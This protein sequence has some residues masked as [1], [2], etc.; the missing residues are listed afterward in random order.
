[1][2]LQT[3]SRKQAKIKMALQGP[4]GS[5]KTKSALLIAYGLCSCWEQIAVIDTEN[6]SADL[7]ADLGGYKVLPLQAPFTP[8]RYIEAIGVCI[9]AGMQ[10][11]I[12]DSLSHE[13]E[14]IGGVLD[15]HSHMIGNSFTNWSKLTPRHNAFVQTML[16]ANVHVIGTI[17][18]KQEY[19]LS[20]KN[21]KQVPEKVGLKGIQR[22][23]LDYEFTIAFDL[24][25]SLHAKASK[26][27]T[28]LFFNQPEFILS[29]DTGRRIL[30]WCGR[31]AGK[32]E[33]TSK[34]D[35]QRSI[36]DSNSIDQLLTLHQA[37]PLYQEELLPEFTKRRQDIMNTNNIANQ[38]HLQNGIRSNTK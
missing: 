27:R 35:M 4:S 1:M 12:I 18:S 29:A 26:D 3:A 20:D 25:I 5:G 36:K 23:G 11:I 8:E 14:G 37:Y 7:Y 24:N 19:V 31:G 16:Q 2:Q 30:D 32:W 22:D 17:R 38:N 21:G 28:Q 33:I 9:N 10:V 34:E 15:I 13:W 6:R